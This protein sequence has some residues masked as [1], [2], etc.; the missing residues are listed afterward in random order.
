M[1]TALRFTSLVLCATLLFGSCQKKEKEKPNFLFV[2][3]DDQPPFDFKIY[4]PNSI[5]ET[6]TIDKLAQGGMIFESARHRGHGVVQYVHHPG[7]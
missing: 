1:K 2:V 6:P 7:T 3:V 5:L 4:N